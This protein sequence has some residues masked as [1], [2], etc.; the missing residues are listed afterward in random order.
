MNRKLNM[1]TLNP[2]HS[3]NSVWDP[4]C[5][6]ISFHNLMKGAGK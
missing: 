4:R 1:G 5:P 2:V 3:D 6:M